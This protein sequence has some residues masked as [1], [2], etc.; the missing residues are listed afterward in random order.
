MSLLELLEYTRHKIGLLEMQ[1]GLRRLEGTYVVFR[2]DVGTSC[3]KRT[4][5]FTLVPFTSAMERCLSILDA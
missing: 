3:E 5:S 4:H 2:V 1:N